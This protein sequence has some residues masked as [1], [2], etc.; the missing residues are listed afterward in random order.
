MIGILRDATFSKNLCNCD[1]NTSVVFRIDRVLTMDDFSTSAEC[2]VVAT[3]GCMQTFFWGHDLTAK[4]CNHHKVT[5]FRTKFSD[6]QWKSVAKDHELMI[7]VGAKFRDGFLDLSPLTCGILPF[8]R[9]KHVYHSHDSIVVTELFSGGFSGWTHGIKS[10]IGQGV[11]VHHRWAVDRD[12]DCIEAYSKSHSPDLVG[13]SQQQFWNDFWQMSERNESGKEHVLIHS[14]IGDKWWLTAFPEA[15]DICVASP[16][17]PPWAITNSSPGFARSDGLT[18]VHMMAY[19]AWIRPKIIVIENIATITRHPHWKLIVALFQWAGFNIRGFHNLNLLD[20]IPQRRDRMI[21]IATDARMDFDENHIFDRWPVNRPLSLKSYDAII[22]DLEAWTDYTSISDMEMKLYTDVSLLPTDA[23]VSGHQK[24]SK[25]DLQHYRF[26]DE[27]SYAACFMTS[28]GRPCEVKN[29]LLDQGGLYGSLLMQGNSIRK[30][31]LPE[32]VILQGT[33]GP[34]WVSTNIR[35]AL[36]ILGNCIA[37]PHALWGLI[38]G[39]F[40]LLDFSRDWMPDVLF[41]RA[42]ANHLT[43]STVAWESDDGGFRFFFRGDIVD[44]F[45]KT[46]PMMT[47]IKV[48]VV[49][50]TQE[51]VIFCH[52][53]VQLRDVLM[54]LTRASMPQ[55]LEI[56]LNG[57]KGCSISL[58]DDFKTKS[59]D[60]VVNA[61]VPSRL[62]VSE[63]SFR[64]EERRNSFVCIFTQEGIVVVPRFQGM[65]VVDI[66]DVVHHCHFLVHGH[67]T[68]L[69]QNH[70]GLTWQPDEPCPDCILVVSKDEKLLRKPL[71]RIKIVSFHKAFQT[72]VGRADQN[73][74]RDL[75]LFLD[76]HQIRQAIQAFGWEFPT[77]IPRSDSDEHSI[78]LA[79]RAGALP[80]HF[81]SI[82]TMMII[83]ALAAQIE[84]V[85]RSLL[86]G[87]HEALS[88]DFMTVAI[89]FGHDCIWKGTLPKKCQ[90]Q[91]LFDA[92]SMTAQF[93][94]EETPMNFLMNGQYINPLSMLTSLIGDD[95]KEILISLIFSSPG[96]ENI[97]NTTTGSEG[98]VPHVE[99]LVP[100]SHFALSSN[101]ELIQME[102]D[103][104]DRLTSRVLDILVHNRTCDQCCCLTH[105][106][107]LDLQEDDNGMS[108]IATVDRISKV[109][110]CFQLLGLESIL[111]QLGWMILPNITIDGSDTLHK[112]ML[113]PTTSPTSE[114]CKHCSKTL[115]KSVISSA[116]LAFSLPFHTTPDEGTVFVN[117][118]LWNAWIFRGYLKGNTPFTFLI[119]S[120]DV[121]MK[122]I[123]SPN[124]LRIVCQGKGVNPDRLIHEFVGTNANHGTPH[125]KIMLLNGL[126]GGG[127]AAKPDESVRAKNALATFLLER[128]ADLQVTSVFTE[129]VVTT[130]GQQAIHHILQIQ[131]PGAKLA[132]L[133]KLADSLVL[134]MPDLSTVDAQRRA[135][136]QK[137]VKAQNF[138]THI[139]HP[140]E[141]QLQDD[142]FLNQDDTSCK[143][144]ETIQAG[145]SGIALMSAQDAVPWLQTDNQISQDEL[146]AL[147]LG[148]CPCS[149]SKRC[150]RIIV[151]AFDQSNKP[152]LLSACLHNLG[153]QH[154]KIREV[155]KAADVAVSSTT[156]CAVTAFQSELEVGVWNQLLESPVK[157]CFDLI[158]QTGCH[159]SLPCAPWGRSWRSSQGKCDPSVADSFQVHIR[160]PWAKKEILLKTSG[161][162]GIYITPKAED[163]Q[164]DDGYAIVWLDK[165]LGELKVLAA[166]CPKHF[167]LVKLVKAKGKR[168]NR[169]IRFLKDDFNDM[170]AHLKPGVSPPVQLTCLHFAK[171]APTPIGAMY[172]EVQAWLIEVDWPAK[173]VKPIGS[174][175]WMIGSEVR[176]ESEWASWNNQLI[177]LT[178]FPPKNRS[179]NKV[180]VAGMS[181]KKQEV[182]HQK[183]PQQ[184]ESK[185]NDPWADY[186]YSSGRVLDIDKKTTEV[187]K[188]V[189]AVP[190]TVTGPIE[191]RFQKQD[192]QITELKST[193]QALSGR[194]D[195]Q[196]QY[197]ASFKNDVKKEFEI[198]RSEMSQQVFRSHHPS[199]RH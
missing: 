134:K 165:N 164:L 126:H 90:L 96:I 1:L 135:N 98:T 189:S 94:I 93:F 12:C 136:V 97:T 199:K 70:V 184:D 69:Y 159:L 24:R 137:K 22:H 59:Q 154:L 78:V 139:P 117:I 6:D 66:R 31:A 77:S 146:A 55:V 89:H 15:V 122:F 192:S 101:P 38:N 118:K 121:A 99:T 163:R 14:S 124:I 152:V 115:I 183:N 171:L 7:A 30:F 110:Q 100:Q 57:T 88:L 86:P 147:V 112:L 182:H 37:V 92:L 166:S 18:F 25:R 49:C 21:L 190:R 186:V 53:N 132:A 156:V 120:W 108:I 107:N 58:V 2:S 80:M 195:N 10:L 63:E 151:P 170:Y 72:F 67:E 155:S 125:I 157:V 193:L 54:C 48:E 47:F 150:Q 50:A 32:I 194:I 105:F 148:T 17:C 145:S 130:V 42:L 177:L 103:S 143:Q 11:K 75:I 158:Q 109:M 62:M 20:H 28:Y 3:S 52:S 68:C 73:A 44:H 19:M 104:F 26:R 76:T 71:Y 140:S 162:A 43:A 40:F 61:N 60:I 138:A 167:G 187:S 129:K 153:K 23:T 79:S 180:V 160:I 133:R 181:S 4:G 113:K 123:G 172:D 174:D 169:G 85:S 35:Q 131:Q 176:F 111:L 178:W 173:P 29:E 27:D 34:C 91:V 185:Q 175:A 82:K 198:V 188:T 65:R 41:S 64:S 5:S 56:R 36:K 196:E 128:G 83:R 95:C 141:F 33:S 144:I 106:E 46:I 74:I 197:Q 39:L 84:D 168:I 127:K 87:F 191:D 51:Y 16:P 179:D 102:T 119:D 9:V 8:H 13:M 45:P 81:D 116:L 114:E 161:M 142:F 149:D